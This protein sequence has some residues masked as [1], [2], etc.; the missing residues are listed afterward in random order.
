MG[1]AARSAAR[2]A[3]AVAAVTALAFALTGCGGDRP[4]PA[5]SRFAEGGVAVSVRVESSGGGLRVVADLRPERDGFHL[6]SLALP[7]GGIDGIG[8]PTR[9]GAEGALRPEGPAST[10]AG[11]RVL[12]PAG[13]DVGL[14]VYRDGQ[15]TLVLP[16]RRVTG[17]DHARV[18]LSYGACSERDGC[19]MP[20]RDRAVTLTLDD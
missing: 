9:I 2:R 7:D 8:I 3:G 14:P 16:V 19:L 5:G 13:L 6:Y 11:E 4:A 10:D 1:V 18:M 12:R 17:E 20:V 15:V